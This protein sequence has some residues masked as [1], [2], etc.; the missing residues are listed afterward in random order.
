MLICNRSRLQVSAAVLFPRR[1]PAY[2]PRTSRRLRAPRIVP[3][4]TIVPVIFAGIAFLS[5]IVSYQISDYYIKTGIDTGWSIYLWAVVS[6]VLAFFCGLIVARLLLK[7]VEKFV[8]ETK[9]LPAL[10]NSHPDNNKRSQD[11]LEHFSRVFEQITDV[12]SKVEA[13]QLFP[14]II[15]QS[16]ALRGIL[17]QVLKVS[18]TDSTVLISGESGTGKEIVADSI[19]ENSL[20][21]HKPFIKTN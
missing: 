16:V 8:K 10:A 19:Y 20:R 5:T 17:N 15:G 6:T 12:L 7:P 18:P 9:R 13:R 3:S 14:D 1:I 11:D 2:I 21:K 4:A